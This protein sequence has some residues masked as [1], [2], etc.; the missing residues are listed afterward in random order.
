MKRIFSSLIIL[1]ILLSLTVPAYGTDPGAPWVV[2]N[3]DLLTDEEEA[4]LMEKIRLSREALGV[5]MVIVTT[6]S[7]NGQDAAEYADDF[8]ERNGYGYGETDSGILLLLDMGSRQWYISTCGEA[9]DIFPDSVLDKMGGR[10]L[11]DLS[12]GQYYSAFVTFLDGVSDYTEHDRNSPVDSYYPYAYL[13]P[14]PQEPQ[15]I[16]LGIPIVI[17]LAAA[18]I[19]ILVMR[20]QMNT[21]KLQ[22]GAADYMKSGSFRLLQNHDIYLYSRVTKTARTKNTSSGGSST[23]RSSGGVRH[24]GRGGRF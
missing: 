7:T 12:T 22:K 17:G 1:L 5:D 19:T 8:Y 4:S 2:D 20:G 15:G 3:A 6:Y 18:T 11:S 16:Q 13:S 9:I 14:A 10:M 24:G 21:A 23:H